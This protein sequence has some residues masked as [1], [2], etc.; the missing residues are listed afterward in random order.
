M[1]SIVSSIK[2]QL[3]YNFHFCEARL[4]AMMLS[5]PTDCDI[6][7]GNC[8]R[9]GSHRMLQTFSLKVAKFLWMLER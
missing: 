3:Q 1:A 9:H 7:D 6:Y 2:F 8:I 4:E 5:N